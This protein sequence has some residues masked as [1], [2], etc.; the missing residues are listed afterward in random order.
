[1]LMRRNKINYLFQTF[2]LIDSVT[3][4]DNLLLALHYTKLG[5]REK[6]TLIRQTLERFSMHGKLD[7]RVNELSGGEKQRVAISRAILKPGGLILADEPTGS[8]DARMANTV[9]DSLISAAKDAGKTLIVVTHDM[10][11]AQKCDRVLT[12]VGGRLG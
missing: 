2:A 8:L 3:V 11:M 6:A 12:M 5:K 4:G 10:G 9:M 7:S 1:M